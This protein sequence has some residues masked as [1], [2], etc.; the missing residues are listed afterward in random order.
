MLELIRKAARRLRLTE[1]LWNMRRRGGSRLYHPASN[2][3]LRARTRKARGL[4]EKIRYKMARDRRPLLTVFADKLETKEYVKRAVGPEHVPVTLAEADSAG[5]LPWSNLPEEFAAK[6]NHGSGACVISWQGAEAGSQVPEPTLAN[7]WARAVVRPSAANPEAIGAFLDLHLGLSYAWMFGEL[8][9][10]DVRPRAFAEE[11][12]PGEAG[13]A[14][15]DYRMYCF[16][17]RCE[18]V[19]VISLNIG[20]P[21]PTGARYLTDFF[22]RNWVHLD[23]SRDDTAPHD[24]TPARPDDL[25]QMIA[26]ANELSAET[27]FLRVD[28]I[29]SEGRILVSELINFPNAGLI[30]ATPEAF[31]RWLGDLW[32]L[33]RDYSTLPQGAY[34]LPPADPTT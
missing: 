6:V 31:E 24:P 15:V 3:L 30:P 28:L 13:E 26:I 19:M 16:G 23:G 18:V 33:P 34:P 11:Y 17:G 9:Y 10:R 12:L 27:D 7:S 2:L 29:R 25:D 5:K 8:A 21:D 4:N 20:N 1:S 32:D 22:D 14:P